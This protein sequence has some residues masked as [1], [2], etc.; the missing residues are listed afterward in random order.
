MLE[1]LK[2]ESTDLEW[3]QKQEQVPLEDQHFIDI[4]E[5]SSAGAFGKD[6]IPEILRFLVKKPEMGVAEA[7]EELGLRANMDAVEKVIEDIV[8]SK[9]SS[10]EK[11]ARHERSDR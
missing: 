9:R 7:I 11:R 2:R 4:F 10:Y 8:N 6:A 5:Q 1:E 3:E